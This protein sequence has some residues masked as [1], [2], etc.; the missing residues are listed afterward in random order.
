MFVFCWAFIFSVWRWGSLTWYNWRT[1]KLSNF[2]LN[3][4]FLVIFFDFVL[5]VVPGTLQKSF[6]ANINVLFCSITLKMKMCTSKP[7]KLI[8]HFIF[9]LSKRHTNEKVSIGTF[10]LKSAPFLGFVWVCSKLTPI[11]I[12]LK[13]EGPFSISFNTFISFSDKRFTFFFQYIVWFSYIFTFGRRNR[14]DS[15]SHSSTFGKVFSWKRFVYSG[16]SLT[17]IYF[18]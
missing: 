9:S 6:F 1:K 5:F 15:F 18:T 11:F 12:I 10:S 3:P 16:V 17:V 14:I 2:F 7:V 4:Y 13:A 8:I